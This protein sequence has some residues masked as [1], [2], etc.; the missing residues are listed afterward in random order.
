M[1]NL[2]N[3]LPLNRALGIQVT[4]FPFS[5]VARIIPLRILKDPWCS[6]FSRIFLNRASSVYPAR[7]ADRY[8]SV[9]FIGV[10][11][12]LEE[13]GFEPGPALPLSYFSLS[14][15]RYLSFTRRV[16]S[17]PWHLSRDP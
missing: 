4:C 8:S 3:F 1:T 6:G 14:H 10:R 9:S 12:K 15:P 5:L 11:T 17:N 7:M 13:P 2:V 16:T